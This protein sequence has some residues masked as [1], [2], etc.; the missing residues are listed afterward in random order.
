MSKLKSDIIQNTYKEK[1]ICKKGHTLSWEGTAYVYSEDL[2]CDKC[3]KLGKN[4]NPIRWRCSK[5][6]NY[7]CS[8]CFNLIMDKLCPR[9]HKYKFYKQTTIE[10]FSYYT[11]DICFEKF[12]SKDGVFWDKDCNL[13]VCSKCF[14][15][16][17][18]VP[19]IL[20]D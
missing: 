11:C 6:N 15:D 7:F 19:E 17:C 4:E 3:S 5:C 18:D 12:Y 8:L 13:T 16:S 1:Y 14:Y 9:N 20:E 2:V 10:G